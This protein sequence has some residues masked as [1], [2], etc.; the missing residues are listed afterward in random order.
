MPLLHDEKCHGLCYRDNFP[1]ISITWF[2]KGVICTWTILH[3]SNI[4]I[5]I[6][7]HSCF[8]A[9]VLDCSC[10]KPERFSLRMTPGCRERHNLAHYEERNWSSVVARMLSEINSTSGGRPPASELLGSCNETNNI[11]C[12]GRPLSTLPFSVGS[13]SWGRRKPG[14]YR[15]AARF[16]AAV[17]RQS[18]NG[19]YQQDQE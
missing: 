2:E 15:G 4:Y 11:S 14:T 10:L 12:L 3:H 8:P 1:K 19:R 7:F 18:W 17:F 6:K 9:L 16:I 13:Q 5:H